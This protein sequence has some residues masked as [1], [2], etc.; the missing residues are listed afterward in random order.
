M[1]M[2]SSGRSTLPTC[3]RSS[4][5]AATTSSQRHVTHPPMSARSTGSVHKSRRTM[6]KVAQPLQQ[7]ITA[8]NDNKIFYFSSVASHTSIQ[9]SLL[10]LFREASVPWDLPRQL[11]NRLPGAATGGQWVYQRAI[12]SWNAHLH[13]PATRPQRVQW[14]LQEFHWERPDRAVHHDGSGAGRWVGYHIIQ[15]LLYWYEIC[16]RI[17]YISLHLDLDYTE[18][19]KPQ[20]REMQV[21][22][23]NTDK[24]VEEWSQ[25]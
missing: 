3:R 7:N 15:Q 23:H 21:K 25:E 4:M 16:N 14:G 10:F 8:T 6:H 12:P 13:I 19:L 17:L 11:C 18:M 1:I 5:R 24:E 9:L 20:H 22:V 2:R